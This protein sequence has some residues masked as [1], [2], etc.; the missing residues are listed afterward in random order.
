MA[1]VEGK[2]SV[3]RLELIL[4]SVIRAETS[5][6]KHKNPIVSNCF[7]CKLFQKDSSFS[8]ARYKNN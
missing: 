3:E 2:S 6:N 7:N 4:V 8:R 1:V 5:R